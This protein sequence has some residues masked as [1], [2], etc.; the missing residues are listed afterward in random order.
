MAA[1]LRDK[2][3]RLGASTA[4]SLFKP[5]PDGWIF[6]APTPWVLGS[7]PH[8]LVDE[9]QKARIEA[10]LGTSHTVAYLLMLSATIAFALYV[11]VPA[12]RRNMPPLSPDGMMVFALATLVIPFLQNLY[13]CIAVRRVIRHAPPTADKIALAERLKLPASFFPAWFLYVSLAVYFLFLAFATHQAFTGKAT[14]FY[15]FTVIAILV[16][17]IVYIGALLWMKLRFPGQP[18]Q[19]RTQ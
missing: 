6:R 16:C 1:D 19:G 2:L 4:R 15:S 11:W 12:I 3:R 8:Y 14:I 13:H 9:T 5:A 7:R 10:M 17:L 18:D